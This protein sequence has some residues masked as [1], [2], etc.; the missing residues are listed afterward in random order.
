MQ[1]SITYYLRVK[2]ANNLCLGRWIYKYNPT[3]KANND[4]VF[5]C[6]SADHLGHPLHTEKMYDTMNEKKHH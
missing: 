2:R 5:K 4:I 1:M 6:E 3:I